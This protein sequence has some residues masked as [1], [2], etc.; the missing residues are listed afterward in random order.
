LRSRAGQKLR[1]PVEH[2]VTG[3]ELRHRQRF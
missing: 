3:I 1:A 2:A